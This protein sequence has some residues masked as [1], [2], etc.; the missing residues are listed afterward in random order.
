MVREGAP[1]MGF[2]AGLWL[3]FQFLE[4]QFCAQTGKVQPFVLP[5]LW[6]ELVEAAKK[7]LYFRVL[8]S[9]RKEIFDS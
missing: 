4:S 5:W 1:G 7:F 9:R 6:I 8:K 3:E 2:V